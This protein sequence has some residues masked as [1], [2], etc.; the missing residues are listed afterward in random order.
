LHPSAD[1]GERS[2]ENDF[3]FQSNDPDGAATPLWAHIRKVNPRDEAQPQ[4][5]DVSSH[6]MIRR[7][8]PFDHTEHK[9]PQKRLHF[10]SFVADVARQFEFVQRRWSDDV[11]FPNGTPPVAPTDPYS[12]PSAG[13]AGAGPDPLAGHRADGVRVQ[14]VPSAGSA[15]QPVTLAPELV[16][17]TGGEYLFAPSLRALAEI[18]T[19]VGSHPVATGS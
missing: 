4:P 15:P 2:S 18:A 14:Y 7:G 19:S 16:T 12:Q 13:V 1:P 11:N 3:A 8:I 6:R 9:N 17:M 10:I 5:E